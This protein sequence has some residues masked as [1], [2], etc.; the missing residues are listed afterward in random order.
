MPPEMS[1]SEPLKKVGPICKS[2]RSFFVKKT[3]VNKQI[4]IILFRPSFKP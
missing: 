4:A 2:Q 3:M 1:E